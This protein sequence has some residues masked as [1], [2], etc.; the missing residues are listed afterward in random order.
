MKPGKKLSRF[1]E[2]TSIIGSTA[3]I[4]MQLTFVLLITRKKVPV[5]NVV[6]PTNP[7]SLSIIRKCSYTTNPQPQPPPTNTNA[8]AIQGQS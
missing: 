3:S 6:F 8:P 5:T 1:R 2:A 4:S 7:A